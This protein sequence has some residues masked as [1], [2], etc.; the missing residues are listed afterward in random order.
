M[1]TLHHFEFAD[2][3][4]SDVPQCTFYELAPLQRLEESI[5]TLHHFEFADEANSDVPQCTPMSWLSSSVFRKVAAP[6]STLNLRTRQTLMCHSAR[7]CVGSASV[8]R[9]V[10]APYH[11]L[12]LWTRQ[13]LMCH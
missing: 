5:S 13:T 3:A 1:G 11:T 12:N 8:F 4:N 10:A 6:Y 2:E 9:E 7:P